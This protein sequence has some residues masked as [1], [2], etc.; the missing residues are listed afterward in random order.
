[1]HGLSGRE[2]N[3]EQVYSIN[4]TSS[5]AI[6]STNRIV[7]ATVR[8]IDVRMNVF[9][10][11]EPALAKQIVIYYRVSSAWVIPESEGYTLQDY[12]NGTYAASFNAVSP[13][14]PVEVSVHVTDSRDIFVQAN[15]T[16]VDV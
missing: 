5:L 2:A 4:V 8:Q 13:T 15:A 11:G 10:E 14:W 12:G 16:S 7:N 6:T 3:V 9:N 1:M